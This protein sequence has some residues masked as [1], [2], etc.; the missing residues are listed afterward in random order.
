MPDARA[1]LEDQ[2]ASAE[3]ALDKAADGGNPDLL[4]PVN[5]LVKMR[6]QVL[7]R[8][9]RENLDGGD[10]IVDKAK[11]EQSDMLDQLSGAKQGDAEAV[12]A[13]REALA[14]QRNADDDLLTRLEKEGVDL[15]DLGEQMAVYGT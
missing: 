6:T 13:M 1:V 15:E 4:E 2:R 3:E 12:N 10:E 14:A 5:E 7:F 11:E 8:A 9:V